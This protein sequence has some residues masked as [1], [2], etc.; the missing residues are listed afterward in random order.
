MSQPFLLPGKHKLESETW[1][2]LR[3]IYGRSKIQL[4]VGRSELFWP[5]YLNFSTWLCYRFRI[6]IEV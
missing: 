6:F 5:V 4:S 1:K 2:K 3:A